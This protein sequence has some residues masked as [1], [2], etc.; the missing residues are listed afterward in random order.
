MIDSLRKV[1]AG[2]P[3]FG[4]LAERDQPSPSIVML[5]RAPYPLDA[6]DIRGSIYRAVPGAEVRL[7]PDNEHQPKVLAGTVNDSSVAVI[8]VPAPYVP[9]PVRTGE[10]ISPE[11]ERRRFI[12]HA[13]WMSV[14]Y[15]GGPEAEPYAYVGKIAS[16]LVDERC[17]LLLVPETDKIMQP[18][19]HVMSIL[20]SGA[21]S[22]GLIGPKATTIVKVDPDDPG[23]LAASREAKSR[24]QEFVDAFDEHHRDA[25]RAALEDQSFAVK[26]PFSDDGATEHM[27]VQVTKIENETIH[28]TLDSLPRTV[29]HVGL[30]QPVTVHLEDLE[31]WMYTTG[32]GRSHATIGGFSLAALQSRASEDPR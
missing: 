19:D 5:L 14:D 22:E 13:A 18:T 17:V 1:L 20:R 16:E 23:V 12:G 11:A 2:I 26:M 6:T 8:S 32:I 7:T 29:T 4:W 24:W 21:W 9:D 28:G 27:W 31:D 3:G 10:R 30:G 25:E 15:L